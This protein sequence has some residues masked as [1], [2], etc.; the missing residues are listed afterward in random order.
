MRTAF[1]RPR[2][3]PGT[4]PGT[5]AP[6]QGAPPPRMHV[7]AF[8][9]GDLEEFDITDP[10]DVR[11]LLKKW[12]MVWVNVDGLGAV[13]AIRALGDMLNLHPLALED[14]FNTQGRAKTDDFDDH[15]FMIMREAL[16]RDGAM[17]TD[18][19]CLFAGK[20]YVVTLQQHS[21]DCLDPVRERIRKGGRRIR[22]SHPDY[23]A[24]AIV[25]AVVD[26]YFPVLENLGDRLSE[27]E[28]TVV[29]NPGKAV[30]ADTHGLKRELRQLR[31]AV[32][33]MREMVSAFAS[34]SRIVRE[35]TRPYLRDCHDH[36]IQVLDILET[37]RERASSLT[38]IYLSSISN[39]MN[40]IIKVLTIITTIFIPLSFIA[41]VYG[42]NFDTQAGPLNMPELHSPVGYP[43]ILALMLAIACALLFYFYRKGW[44]LDSSG[45]KEE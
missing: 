42:M 31:Q 4:P 35:E 41:G 17:I 11:P 16:I 45:K 15:V 21:G 24:Y 2:H 23:L 13:E 30:L 34:S 14:V 5:L 36:V 39:R 27:L 18:Q 25:D 33:P 19:I 32:W 8:S 20:K 9:E 7:M 1:H 12:P 10:E 37:Y 29:E 22:M 6:V 40:E 38:D 26:G 44:L 28:D 43:A 3:K